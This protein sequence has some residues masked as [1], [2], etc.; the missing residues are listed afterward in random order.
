MVDFFQMIP[1]ISFTYPIFIK[2]KGNVSHLILSIN[3][4]NRP[5]S[6]LA[7]NISFA[8]SKYS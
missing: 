4:P 1:V 8:L 2:S 7:I 3:R 5:N 6:G